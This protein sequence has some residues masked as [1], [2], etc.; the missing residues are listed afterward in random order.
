[1]ATA[2]PCVCLGEQ[3]CGGGGTEGVDGEEARASCPSGPCKAKGQQVHVCQGSPSSPLVL[4]ASTSPQPTLQGLEATNGN[5]RGA[6]HKLEQ[7]CSALIVIGLHSLP[8]PLHQCGALA[9][10]L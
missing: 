9:A 5:T 3:V 7:S 8:E 6:S 4:C 10:V 1:M 2:S